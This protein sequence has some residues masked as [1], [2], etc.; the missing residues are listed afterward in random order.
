MEV[1]M[2]PDLTHPRTNYE[3]VPSREK[4]RY[5]NQI[6]LKRLK[7]EHYLRI[8][9]YSGDETEEQISLIKPGNNIL[10]PMIR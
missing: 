5:Q 9:D 7:V 10:L 8:L 4:S 1:D 6:T 3:S 2:N